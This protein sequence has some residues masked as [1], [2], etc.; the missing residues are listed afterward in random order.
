MFVRSRMSKKCVCVSPTDSLA[1]AY[2]AIRE[3]G[4]EGLPV[5]KDGKVIGVI[6]M[7]D[8]LQR[9]AETDQPQTYLSKT[10]VAEVMTKQPI[11]IREDDIIEEAAL[12][13]HKHDIS[14][15]PVINEHND[16]VGILTESDFLRI[17]VE[18]L[19]LERKGTRISLMVSDKVGELARLTEVVREKGFSIISLV[20]FEPGRMHADVVLRVAGD[21]P[22]P[23]VDALVEAG[24]RVTHVSQVWA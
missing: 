9:L 16:V 3:K 20:T 1:K 18:A 12:L 8:I 13:M 6:T 4:F 21:D 2:A 17:F 5:A 10:L 23:V 19:G 7:W 24:F 14:L 11:T 22:K 15:L